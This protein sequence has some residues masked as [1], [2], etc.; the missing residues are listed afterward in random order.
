[1]DIKE[2]RGEEEVV[3][4][5]D[6]GIDVGGDTIDDDDDDEDEDEDEGCDIDAFAIIPAS[7]ASAAV[8]NNAL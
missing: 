7:N 5:E 8:S 6:E 2:R 4:D 3:D 1:M